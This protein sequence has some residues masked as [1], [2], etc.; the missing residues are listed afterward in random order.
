M[1]ID[2]LIEPDSLRAKGN[3]AAVGLRLPWYRALP[4]STV[5]V[6]SVKIDGTAIDPNRLTILLEGKRWPVSEMRGV[7][8]HNWFVTDTADLLIDNLPL[9]R[10]SNHEVEVMVSLYPPYIKGLRRAFRW[11]RSMEVK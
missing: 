1:M 3:G 6:D 7:T 4:L 2:K 11:T 9:E 10:G 5:E 8:N